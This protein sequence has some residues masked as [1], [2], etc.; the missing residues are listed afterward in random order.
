MINTFHNKRSF[1]L[2]YGINTASATINATML[3]IRTAAAAMSFTFPALSSNCGDTISVRRSIE[4]F[5]SS[6]PS[7]E[8]M[9]I[10][11]ASHSG[12]VMPKYN[13]S[14]VIARVEI[15]WSLKFLSSNTTF[16]PLKAK[17]KDF[18][19]ECFFKDYSKIKVLMLIS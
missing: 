5:T 7:T 2:I 3:T 13:P 18:S 6:M 11:I 17:A 4:V 1:Y 10:I 16:R 19:I 15:R 14:K 12:M 9:Q 8:P